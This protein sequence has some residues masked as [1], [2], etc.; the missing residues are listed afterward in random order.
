MSVLFITH[1][2]GVVAEVAKRVIVMYAGQVVESADT[3]I[4]MK[5]PM[6]PY[7]KGLLA[8]LPRLS[9]ELDE[10]ERLKVI[11]GNV[12]DAAFPPPACSFH[13][14][15]SYMESGRCDTISP[16]IEWSGN[17]HQVR[18]L[19]WSEILENENADQ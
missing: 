3:R 2:L 4:T 11:P 18:C 17:D 19:R 15:C 6:H 12:P 8:S 16:A 1:D 5:K 14:R 7:T 13:P 9:Q 10:S